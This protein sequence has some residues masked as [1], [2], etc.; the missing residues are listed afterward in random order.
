MDLPTE[1]MWCMIEKRH[2]RILPGD[3]GWMKVRL[4]MR[5]KIMAVLAAALLCGLCGC[6]ENQLPDFTDDEVRAIGEQAA[7]LMMKYDAGHRSRL[8]DLSE[9]VL[10]GRK[11]AVDPSAGT[12]PEDEEPSGMRPTEDTPVTVPPGAAVSGENVYSME[13]V[14][15][16]PGGVAVSFLGHMVC[17]S[18]PSGSDDMAGVI[19]VDAQKGKKLLVLRFALENASGQDLAVDL[20]SAGTIFR[21]TVN[22]AYIR[23]AFPTAGLSDDL[24]TFKGTLPAGGNA[25]AVLIVEVEN[26]MAE[27]ISSVSLQVG[28]GTQKHTRQLLE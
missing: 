27:N 8:M 21:V 23:R 1:K 12:K 24:A 19:S 22:G 6:A 2:E 10:Y 18:Y 5:K 7:F 16:L 15:G 25:E 3:N 20:V 26:T 28:N 14:M 4:K 13:E 17:D 9:D 11:P